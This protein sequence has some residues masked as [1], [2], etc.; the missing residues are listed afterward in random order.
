[1]HM[2]RCCEFVARDHASSE[3]SEVGELRGGRRAGRAAVKDGESAD[4]GGAGRGD[5]EGA[6]EQAGGGLLPGRGGA[7]VR[8][9]QA[10]CL[11][12]CEKTQS[13]GNGDVQKDMLARE[14]NAIR[15]HGEETYVVELRQGW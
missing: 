8:S 6:W 13:G 12:L 5:S 3:A 7:V 4:T 1:M 10:G 14:E 15:L 2:D 9:A 11:D